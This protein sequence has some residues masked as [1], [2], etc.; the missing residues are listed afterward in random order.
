M[1][2]SRVEILIR[3]SYLT[4]VRAAIGTSMFRSLH[5]LVGGK[6]VDILGNGQ[7]SCALFV[8]TILVGFG[9]IRAV[10]ATVESTVA[11][12]ERSGWTRL[13]RPKKGCVV[14]WKDYLIGSQPHDH[15]GFY[16]GNGR[17]ISNSSALG[18]PQEHAYTVHRVDRLF[19]HPSLEN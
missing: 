6:E 14:L 5:A 7:K 1:N 2:G 12:M 11:D 18:S 16:M 13:S 10:H 8:S 17:A 4:R 9:L 15:I 19:W 3:K